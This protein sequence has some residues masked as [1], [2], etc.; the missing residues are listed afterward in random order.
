VLRQIAKRLVVDG[1]ARSIEMEET[2]GVTLRER[3]L[4][5]E[6]RRV[7]VGEIGERVRHGA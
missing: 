7:I 3:T 1:P 4:S 6:L 2:A 5:D